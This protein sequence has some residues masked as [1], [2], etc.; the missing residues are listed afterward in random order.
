ML[1]ATVLLLA[2]LAALNPISAVA[3]G[4]ASSVLGCVSFD[5]LGCGCHIRVK[6]LACTP[7]GSTSS[8]H[9]FTGLEQSEPLHLVLDGQPVELPH[10]ARHGNSDKGDRSG[11]WVDEY[12]KGDLRVRISYTPGTS[13]CP[14]SKE[15]PCEY[16]D[17]NA[18]VT[19]VKHPSKPHLY[20]STAKCGC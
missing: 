14:K 16:T 6:R 3:Q 10:T 8:V 13:T 7:A 5:K 18:T 2:T 1:R 17:Y 15:E 4:E 20:R 19:M 12:S 11:R 9:F